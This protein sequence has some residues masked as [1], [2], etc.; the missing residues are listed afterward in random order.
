MDTA[1]VS[2]HA[3]SADDAL[4]SQLACRACDLVRSPAPS[5]DQEKF[6]ELHKEVVGL[7]KMLESLL[8]K[9]GGRSARVPGIPAR[10]A[11]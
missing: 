1:F 9:W 11:R 3:P 2:T 7:R 10:T 6:A 4:R 8:K 5:P